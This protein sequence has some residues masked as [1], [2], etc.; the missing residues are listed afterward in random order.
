MVTSS[1]MSSLGTATV[2]I[3]VILRKIHA[4]HQPENDSHDIL[5]RSDNDINDISV[6]MDMVLC[7]CGQFYMYVVSCPTARNV[8]IRY[9]ILLFQF[10]AFLNDLIC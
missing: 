6:L 5:L 2:T 9:T 10:H 4:P 8:T 7:K 3:S 1:Q